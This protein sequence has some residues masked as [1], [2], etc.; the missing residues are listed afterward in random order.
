MR[1]AYTVLV[2][3]PD[4]KRTLGRPRCS[5]K[6]NIEIEERVCVCVCVCVCARA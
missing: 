2:G 6:Y 1:Y 3:E 5:W 4:R